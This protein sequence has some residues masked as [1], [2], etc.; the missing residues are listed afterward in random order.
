M[1]EKQSKEFR[2][3]FVF[4]DSAGRTP[5]PGDLQALGK[6]REIADQLGV[7]LS[8]ILFEIPVF[9]PREWVFHGADR[10]YLS[11]Q[12][13]AG[14]IG[15]K[16]VSSEALILKESPEIVLFSSRFPGNELAGRL[17]ERFRVGLVAGCRNLA[18]DIENRLLIMTRPAF[19]GK[20]SHDWIIPEGRPQMAT[21]AEGAFPEGFRDESREG[22]GISV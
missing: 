13:S 1:E 2:G 3:V 11:S 21:L 9:T 14:N 16:V 4:V 17:A 22:E 20:V 5:H 15:K 12:S 18:M 19:G 10:V 6:G 8:A 7:Y